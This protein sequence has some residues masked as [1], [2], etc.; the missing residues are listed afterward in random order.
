M[1]AT[2]VDGVYDRDPN[3]FKEAKKYSS[4][5]YQQVLS[6]EI[7]V[8]DSTAIALCKDNNIPIMVF[9]IFKKGNISRA[10]AG[11]SIGSLIS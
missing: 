4:L 3:K 11:E 9:D 2:K 10:V 5:T 1:K 7:A 6:D 8:M